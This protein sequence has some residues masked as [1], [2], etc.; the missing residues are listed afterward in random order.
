[1]YN[2]QPVKLSMN[3]HRV[4]LLLLS[5]LITL[6]AAGQKGPQPGDIYREYAVNLRTG[7][8][9]RVTD[10][11]AGHPGAAEHLPNPTLS[12]EIEDLDRAV[13]AEVM[14]DIWGGHVGTTQRRFRFNGNDWIN[15]PQVP[16]LATLPNCYLSQHNV[17]VNLPL[18]YIHEGH[19]TFSGTSGGQVCQSFNWG[20]WGWYVMMVRVYF[21]EEKAHTEGRISHP[22]PG[23]TIMENPD[24]TI[25]P[26]DSGSVSAIQLL[27]NYRGYDENGDGIYTDWHRAYH[28]TGISGHIGTATEPPYQVKWDTRYLPDQ[29]AGSVSL[30]GRIKDTSGIWYVTEVVDSL[31][32]KRPDSLRVRMYT[33]VGM[34][35]GFTVRAGKTK[36]CNIRIDSL[37]NAMEA[38]LYHRTW[39]AGDD[40]A[41]GGTIDKPLLV[42]GNSYPCYGKN[43]FFA[44]SNV[45]LAVGD[46]ITGLNRI[47][48][49][50]DTEHHGIEVLWPGPAIV[51]R[52]VNG[53]KTVSTPI[54]SPPDGETFQGMLY[55]EFKME[56][57][58]A[59]VYYTT[60]GTD[61]N[62]SDRMYN[63]IRIRVDRTMTVRARAFKKDHF[64]SDVATA[65]YTKDITAVLTS[66]ESRILLYPNPATES[67]YLDLSP[68]ME[69]GTF[70]IIDSEGRI[71]LTGNLSGNLIDTSDLGD[72]L[73]ILKYNKEQ[74]TF[75]GRFVIN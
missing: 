10:P 59:K 12:I 58:G 39:N 57:E 5:C 63:S 28:G 49:T 38:W 46:L 48:Y 56:T 8:N 37:Q 27:G 44:L 69:N 74:D 51:V 2:F 72:G 31:T 70:S 29:E 43:H 45:N 18:E 3:Y 16:I 26:D 40:G 20:Q 21:S 68:E 47:A 33:A 24:I 54:F 6:T 60:D 19:N 71:V 17:I 13:R 32:L 42:N 34:P 11:N 41:A 65:S 66:E 75:T 35:Q 4:I 52:Y 53:A 67:I 50:S 30:M 25:V 55:P 14:M 62:P 23:D 22:I 64:E 36:Y 73:Y 1:M 15:I 7:D 61:P 9:W